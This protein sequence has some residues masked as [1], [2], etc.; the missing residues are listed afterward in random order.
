MYKIE[1]HNNKDYLFRYDKIFK[2]WIVICQLT[3][4]EN[5]E[6]LIILLKEYL[7]DKDMG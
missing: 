4:R 5:I 2:K 6:E 3:D 1:A 7:N